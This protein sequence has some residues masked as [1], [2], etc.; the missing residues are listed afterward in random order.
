MGGLHIIGARG[1]L[2]S[3]VARQAKRL[4]VPLADS[5][6]TADVVALAIPRRAAGELLDQGFGDQ[7]V[8]DLSGALKD[9]REGRYAL[10]TG[11]LLDDGAPPR[12]GDLLANPGCLA[13][14]VIVG[15]RRAG[16]SS[17][18]PRLG[19][20]HITAVGGASMAGRDQR[21][22][23]RLARRGLTHPHVQEICRAVPGLVPGSFS[24]VV[25]YAQERGILAVI[26]GRAPQGDTTRST[27]GDPPDVTQVL[28]TDAV[29]HH[30]TFTG[31]AF[32]LAVTLDNLTFPAANAA[33]LAQLL[34]RPTA[35]SPSSH[36]L[37]NS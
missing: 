15:L 10:L 14:S 6:E 30:L 3:E 17:Q 23:I 1:R 22:G 4:G 12:A 8:I 33:R 29:H 5:L 28:G 32:T 31:D 20:V 24:P 21:G 26:S 25:C 36:G 9:R 27:G 7:T 2:G 35:H 18:A 11:E 34:M 37:T 13:S 19:P 16:L